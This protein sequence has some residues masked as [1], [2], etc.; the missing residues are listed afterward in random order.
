MIDSYVVVDSGYTG[1]LTLSYIIALNSTGYS[2][3]LDHIADVWIQFTNVINGLVMNLTVGINDAYNI[4]SN[5]NG[6]ALVMPQ[7]DSQMSA[8]NYTLFVGM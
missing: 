5:E 3:N 7:I 4:T 2:N 6:Y 8:G 1:P